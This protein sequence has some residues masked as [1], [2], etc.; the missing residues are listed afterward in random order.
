MAVGARD[1]WGFARKMRLALKVRDLPRKGTF[2]PFDGGEEMDRVVLVKRCS[3][4]SESVTYEGPALLSGAAVCC[5][6]TCEILWDLIT[7][8]DLG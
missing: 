1:L 7:P 8:G 4:C 5:G 2:F 6:E 3:V